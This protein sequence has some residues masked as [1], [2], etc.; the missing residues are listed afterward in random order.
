MIN[1]NPRGRK[2]PF[3]PGRINQRTI[4]YTHDLDRL[5]FG[6][7]DLDV[8]PRTRVRRNIGGFDILGRP[9]IDMNTQEEIDFDSKIRLC[10]FLNK[11]QRDQVRKSR[12]VVVLERKFAR[13]RPGYHAS[14]LHLHSQG[15]IRRLPEFIIQL[16]FF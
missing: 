16:G 14:I 5:N 7:W 4:T 8:A 10:P 6:I 2:I 3:I 1:S 12:K 13:A 9:G 11:A 15:I